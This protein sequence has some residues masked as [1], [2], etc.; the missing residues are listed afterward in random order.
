MM[1]QL[2]P[3][4]RK[5]SKGISSTPRNNWYGASRAQKK[6][7][8]TLKRANTEK[9]FSISYHSARRGKSRNKKM[10]KKPDPPRYTEIDKKKTYD[11]FTKLNRKFSHI[12]SF[13]KT[14]AGLTANRMNTMMKKGLLELVED[15]DCHNK[16]QMRALRKGDPNPH[17][18]KK[19]AIITDE[20][21]QKHEFEN[22]TSNYLESK[23][24]KLKKKVIFD[25]STVS[26]AVNKL[27]G[28]SKLPVKTKQITLSNY[29][30]PSY[31]VQDF[32]KLYRMMNESQ[33]VPNLKKQ[34]QKELIMPLKKGPRKKA[35]ANKRHQ[36]KL[37]HISTLLK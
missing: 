1:S 26:P 11:L 15:P 6:H 3:N 25:C 14:K 12:E 19:T 23:L 29:Q 31:T 21:I 32:K 13:Q 5:A 34:K 33:S 22:R 10:L 8:S 28:N 36:F 37:I 17:L 35:D 16:L 20:E 30:A 9:K 24:P 7:K 4:W 27:I 18:Y 2:N